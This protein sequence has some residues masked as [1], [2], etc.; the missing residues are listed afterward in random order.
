ME[1]AQFIA[2]ILGSSVLGGVLTKVIDWIRDARAGHLSER[3][4]EVDRATQRATEAEKRAADFERRAADSEAAE[5]AAAR[6]TRVVEE[7][8]FVHRRIIIDASCLGPS[9]LPDYP[10]RK[11]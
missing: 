10:S 7:S 2:A 11:D 9:A 6:R 3:R 1:P 8:L 4:A 5:D